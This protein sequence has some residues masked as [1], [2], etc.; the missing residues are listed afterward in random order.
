MR[1]VCTLLFSSISIYNVVWYPCQSW[2]SSLRL[3]CR[4]VYSERY[5]GCLY[6]RSRQLLSLVP[7]WKQERPTV[8]RWLKTVFQSCLLTLSDFSLESMIRT[9]GWLATSV[10]GSQ[11]SNPLL[12]EKGWVRWGMYSE[13]S[14]SGKGKK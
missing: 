3:R 13:N 2:S 1:R 4:C 14:W 6:S 5:L 10:N 12:S 8:L 7:L 11:V 9:C